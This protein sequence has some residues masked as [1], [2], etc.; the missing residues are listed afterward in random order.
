MLFLVI[1]NLILLNLFLGILLRSIKI[2][3]E[4]EKVA[5]EKAIL[6]AIEAEKIE[7]I[8]KQEN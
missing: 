8:N 6:N 7:E 2:M 4:Q 5:H 1:G 3:N